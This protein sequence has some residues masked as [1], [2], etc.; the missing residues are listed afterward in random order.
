MV[1]GKITDA[2]LNEALPFVNIG[3]PGAGIGTVSDEQGYYLLEIPPDK[4]NDSIYFSMV[5]FGF[6]SFKI[7]QIDGTKEKLLNISFQP[8]T[9]A[10]KEVVVTSGKWERKTVGNET[11]SKLITTGFTTNKLGN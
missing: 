1:F 6:Q 10:L 4:V 8:E 9:T 5:G 2:E 11:D 7:D 3:I